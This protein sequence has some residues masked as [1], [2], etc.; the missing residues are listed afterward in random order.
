MTLVRQAREQYQSF[1]SDQFD[2]VLR[3]ALVRWLSPGLPDP[4]DA[5]VVQRCRRLVKQENPGDNTDKARAAA[6]DVTNTRADQLAG[7]VWTVAHR[8]R[9]DRLPKLPDAVRTAKAVRRQIQSIE[10]TAKAIA[11]LINVPTAIQAGQ[12]KLSMQTLSHQ[13]LFNLPL[14]TSL[15]IPPLAQFHLLP[16]ALQTFSDMLKR[17]RKSLSTLE[18]RDN[19]RYAL[20]KVMELKFVETTGSFNQRIAR[21]LLNECGWNVSAAAVEQAV[22][23]MKTIFSEL[24]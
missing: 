12:E 17:V 7:I 16:A 3:T 6:N 21:E 22:R 19:Y 18:R 11:G 5:C 24:Q 23:R 15:E 20:F 1:A 8:G 9:T 10:R 2:N 4:P 13:F 14:S